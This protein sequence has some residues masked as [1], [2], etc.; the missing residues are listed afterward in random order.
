MH[1]CPDCGH[2]CYCHGDIDDCVVETEEYSSERCE[3]DCAEAG[4]VAADEL[5]YHD[6]DCDCPDCARGAK[7]AT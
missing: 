3:C 1:H 7:G 4:W 5:D 6:E 2:A